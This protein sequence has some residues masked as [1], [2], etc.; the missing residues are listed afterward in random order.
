[1]LN[2]PGRKHEVEGVCWAVGGNACRSAQECKEE[3]A[4]MG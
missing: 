4:G 1:M 3:E 2:T